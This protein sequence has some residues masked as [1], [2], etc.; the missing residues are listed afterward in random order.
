MLSYSVNELPGQW[1]S[2]YKSYVGHS[3]LSELCDIHNIL[4]VVSTPAFRQFTVTNQNNF[5]TYYFKISGNGC[6]LNPEYQ[7]SK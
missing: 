7:A 1:L 4:G 3:S 2:L 5:I 6:G